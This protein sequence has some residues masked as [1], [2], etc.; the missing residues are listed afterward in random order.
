[1]RIPQLKIDSE[2]IR[3][4]AYDPFTDVHGPEKRFAVWLQGCPIL[5]DGCIN[6]HMLSE[7]GGSDMRVSQIT[8]L[9]GRQVRSGFPIDGVT[10]MGGE[11]MTQ[12]SGVAQILQWC[13]ENTA[14]NTLLFSGYTLESL[15]ND[16]NTDVRRVLGLIDVLIDGRYMA[17]RRAMGDIR[18]SSNQRI[19]HLNRQRLMGTSFERKTAEFTVTNDSQGFGVDQ[20]GFVP[21]DI[22]I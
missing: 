3:I 2:H 21:D 1:M 16:S 22:T 10:F 13:S 11:P 19:H 12:A 9:I 14:L 8:S 6:P 20:T 17:D 15:R 7:S 5:C 18:G 4:A